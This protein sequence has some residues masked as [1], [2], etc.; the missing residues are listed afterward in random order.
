MYIMKKIIILTISALMATSA[1]GQVKY[2]E[3][4]EQAPYS[5][6]LFTPEKEAEVR[7][8]T[9]SLKYYK[10]V[11]ESNKRLFE[12][13]AKELQYTQEQANLWRSQS[14]ELSRQLEDQRNSSFWKQTLYFGLGALVTT[15]LAFGVNQATK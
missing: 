9:E 6:F 13:Q 4:G 10:L 14:G 15:A 7:Q 11:D 8:N 1:F 5:G 12:L 2:I 3:K